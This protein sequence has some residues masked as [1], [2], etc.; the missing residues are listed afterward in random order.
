MLSECF[1]FEINLKLFVKHFYQN[2][3]EQK[4]ISSISKSSVVLFHIITNIYGVYIYIYIYIYFCNAISNQIVLQILTCTMIWL[5][6]NI[7]FIFK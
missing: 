7:A 2:A 5:G 4:K 3:Y 6:N 1:L